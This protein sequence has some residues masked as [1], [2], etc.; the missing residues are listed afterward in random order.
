MRPQVSRACAASATRSTARSTR[1]SSATSMPG[2]DVV[3]SIAGGYL[4]W[5]A[6]E[7][8][9]EHGVPF[10]VTPYVHPGQHGD[11]ADSVDYYRRSDAVLRPA[12]DRPRAARRPRRAPRPD[13]PLRRRSAAPRSLPMAQ[14]DSARPSRLRRR[15]DRPLRRPH[16]RVQR[17]SRPSGTPR[18]RVW[19]T[20]RPNARFVFIGPGSDEVQVRPWPPSTTG[21]TSSGFVSKQEK[22]DAYAACYCSS[23]CPLEFEILPAVYPRGLELRQARHRGPRPR[24]R[25]HLIEG[26]GAGLVAMH[27]V[28]LR[29]G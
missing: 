29:C 27:S 14:P 2:V 19:A 6:Q 7:V 25:T 16:G 8:A 18:A 11:D 10:V 15:P 3:H 26:H 21:C 24:P 1:R 22:A 20:T 23:A 12:G 9:R 5:T 17:D 4:G 13:S 28:G